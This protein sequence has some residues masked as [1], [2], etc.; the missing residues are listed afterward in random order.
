MHVINEFTCIFMKEI[1]ETT[2]L[3]LTPFMF[4][5]IDIWVNKLLFIV[6]KDFITTINLLQ[7]TNS[8]IT[9]LKLSNAEYTQYSVIY[10]NQ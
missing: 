8:S 5:L 2:C 4:L 10:I 9:G 7:Y 3:F 1:K 6:N